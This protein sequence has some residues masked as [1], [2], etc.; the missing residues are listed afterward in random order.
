VVIA[1]IVPNDAL[2]EDFV[3]ALT[4]L[5]WRKENLTTTS[6]PDRA[7]TTRS[8]SCRSG[9]RRA[10]PVVGQQTAWAGLKMRSARAPGRQADCGAKLSSR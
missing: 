2:E 1:D 6:S 10:L 4:H 3:A 8:A 7:I 9:P 5:L